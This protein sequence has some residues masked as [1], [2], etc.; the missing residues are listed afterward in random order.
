LDIILFLEYELSW[1]RSSKKEGSK[2]H[3]RAFKADIQIMWRKPTQTLPY[4]HGFRLL[5]R[6]KEWKI[7]F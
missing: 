2:H 4:N 6:A 1:K 5:S 7:S 3:L